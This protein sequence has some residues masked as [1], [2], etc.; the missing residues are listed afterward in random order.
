M[1]YEAK[2]H[3]MSNSFRFSENDIIY[4]YWL[5]EIAYPASLMK[6][7]HPMLR[8]CSRAHGFDMYADRGYKPFR[9]E[10]FYEVD[11]IHCINNSGK[12]DLIL[13]YGHYL[14]K[15]KLFVSHLGVKTHDFL[16]R[17][18][19]NDS[20]VL[21]TCSNIIALKR[22]DILVKALSKLEIPIKWYHFGSGEL[23]NDIIELSE[24]LLGKNV[25]YFFMGQT[26]HDELLQFYQNEQ[27]D[28]FINSSDYEGVPVS[29]MEAMSYG[30]PCIARNVGG[31]SELLNNSVGYL[32]DK[33]ATEIQFCEAIA[34]FHSLPDCKKQ[35]L[36]R[37]AYMKIKQDFDMENNYMMFYDRLKEKGK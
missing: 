2:I 23:Y 3:I 4:T 28:L 14:K 31:I 6:K 8:F 19:H 36:S 29:I 18:F 27:I 10:V 20:L 15:C 35:E 22:L 21:V 7:S 34:A 16:P 1:Y 11:Q 37:N 24:K 32:L 30:I 12:E 26:N 13:H 25:K 33:A 9:R 5:S 17:A